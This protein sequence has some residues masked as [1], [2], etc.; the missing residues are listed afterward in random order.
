[1]RTPVMTLFSFKCPG[2]GRFSAGLAAGAAPLE[3]FFSEIPNGVRD[4]Y[5]HDDLKAIHETRDLF[6]KISATPP[7]PKIVL[8]SLSSQ[9]GSLA[10]LRDFRKRPTGSGSCN[11]TGQC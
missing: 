3:G 1:M 4:P 2:F 10:S 7:L 8:A 5:S 6:A 9:Y 11:C